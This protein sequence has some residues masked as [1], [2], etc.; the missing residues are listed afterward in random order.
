MA[1]QVIYNIT[2][3][4]QDYQPIDD[5]VDRAVITSDG[6]EYVLNARGEMKLKSEQ[7]NVSD[8]RLC[9]IILEQM[10]N[11]VAPNGRCK[12]NCF[13]VN[14]SKNQKHKLYDLNFGSYDKQGYF[15]GIVGV[16]KT[17]MKVSFDEFASSEEIMDIIAAKKEYTFHVTLQ[18]ESRLDRDD[19]NKIS[20][21]FFLSTMLLRDKVKLNDSNIPN[22]EDEIF[23]YLLLF[24]F[25]EQLQRAC[26]KGY[27]K[28][29]R[30]FER[31]DDRVKGT[32]DVMRHIRL[33]AGQK[34]GKIAYSYRENTV[35]N[36]LNH[37]IVAAYYQ[38]K[39]KY[40]ELV[41]DNF[42]NH[43]DLKRF[44]DYLSYETGYSGNDKNYLLNQNS[45]SIVHPYFTE[46][47]E[48]R[49]TC[50]RILREEGIS[51]FDG[52][53]Q[54]ETQGILFYL[55]DLW[56]L[57]L[58][59]EVFGKKKNDRVKMEAQYLVKNFGYQTEKRSYQY[60]QKTYPDFVF[61]IGQKP[62]MILDA[63]CKPKWEGVLDGDSVSDVMED[64]NKCIR[65]MVAINS[66]ATGVIFP[67][68]RDDTIMNDAYEKL[69][70]L[71][72]PVSADTNAIFYT[73]PV[74]VPTV[75][76]ESSYSDWLKEFKKKLEKTVAS[77]D[78]IIETETDYFEKIS[79]V[80]EQ[81]RR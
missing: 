46:Y 72:H 28:T 39:K 76:P 2:F 8:K 11:E 56:E 34:N 13:I 25:R 15:C 4:G 53:N 55:P 61:V 70:I 5:A 79:K 10:I 3:V 59:D 6:H 37:L 18:I 16:I 62:F 7:D 24:W 29:Y 45:K 41:V 63:K 58:Q 31:N 9:R 66:N 27:Y 49:I 67:T 12:D 40:Y 48:L 19:N 20:R 81:L 65:D 43:I 74:F 69:R 33:N 14:S 64:Y 73:I 57:F 30:R 36:Y 80:C 38:L 32:I 60:V 77:I 52:D 21:P 22:S 42:D 71:R 51:I 23:D 78:E 50:L 26:L 44:L 54:N 1:A 47:E 35:N 17:Q 75:K 68:N